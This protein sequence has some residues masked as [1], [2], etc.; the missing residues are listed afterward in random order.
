MNFGKIK[1][2]VKVLEN[3][4]DNW[5]LKKFKSL[6][7]NSSKIWLPNLIF[8]IKNSIIHIHSFKHYFCYYY[9]YSIFIYLFLLKIPIIKVQ[10]FKNLTSEFNFQSQKFH[11][12]RWFVKHYFYYHYYYS[13]FSYLFL[14]KIPMIKVQFLKNLIFEFN[15]QSKKFHYSRSF[16]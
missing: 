6:R 12:P 4:F 3:Y 7:F 10:L 15:F 1:F 16:V 2:K 14:L 13:I 11:Y 5:I 9:Y 8:D